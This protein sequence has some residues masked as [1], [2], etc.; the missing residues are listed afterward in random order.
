MSTLE[1]LA[2][3]IG[4]ALQ[5]ARQIEDIE[6]SQKQINDAF[7]Y[8]INAIA[9]AAEANDEDTG[10]HTLRVGMYCAVLA[11]KMGMSDKF[12]EDMR[13][14][15]PLHDIGKTHIHPDI[16]RKP[17]KLTDEEWKIMKTHPYQ[18]A[19]IIGDNPRLML[20][21]SIAYTHHERWDGSGY[22]QGLI[23]GQIP[24]EGRILSIA[25]QYDALRNLRPY[26]PAFDHTIT[27]RIILEGDGRTMP[28]HFD[29]QLLRAFR[30]TVSQFEETYER[31]KG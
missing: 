12:V 17:G 9:R 1:K 27:C 8:A 10:N 15:A 3:Q 26:K 18:G 21:K 24:M 20:A 14:E 19:K 28:H 6:R 13:Q 25:D 5:N 7:I 30:E 23:G 22:P 4:V 11:K 31:L 2:S 16:L 29:P